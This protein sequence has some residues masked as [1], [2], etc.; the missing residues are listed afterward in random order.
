MSP[1]VSFAVAT[2]KSFVQRALSLVAA[3]LLD[4][5]AHP[6][7][8]EAL[9]LVRPDRQIPEPERAARWH[10][11]QVRRDRDGERCARRQRVVQEREI[12]D[13]RRAEVDD[14]RER[15]GLA[16]L[17][18]DVEMATGAQVRLLRLEAPMVVTAV[19]G[20]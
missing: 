1:P 12:G 4:C 17:V 11:V 2:P 3:A 16:A 13:R 9:E 10:E 8:N 15:V 6:G 5:R 7:V 18:D 19:L 20:I 14:L